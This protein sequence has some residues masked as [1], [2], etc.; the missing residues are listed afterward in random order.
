MRGLHTWTIA[1][2]HIISVPAELENSL[3]ARAAK[4]LRE[5]YP[6]GLY[7]EVNDMNGILKRQYQYYSTLLE[8][9][10]RPI[11]TREFLQMILHQYDQSC[12]LEWRRKAGTLTGHDDARWGNRPFF[13]R[14]LKY[15]AES[16]VAKPAKRNGEYSRRTLP[17]RV[18]TIVVAAEQLVA[19]ANTSTQ[20][21]ALLPEETSI[22]I[23]PDGDGQYLSV[24]SPRVELLGFAQRVDAVVRNISSVIPNSENLLHAVGMQ[25]PHVDK[26]FQNSLDVSYTELV[27]LACDIIE[28]IVPPANDFPIPV[29]SHAE[30]LRGLSERTHLRPS[31]IEL[32]IQG[33]S[34]CRGSLA[35][36]PREVFRP[37][38]E[39][40]LYRRGFCLL[41]DED[42]DWV[43]WSRELA[44]ESLVFLVEGAVFKQAPSEWQSPAI[45]SALATLSNVGGEWFEAIVLRGLT[46]NGVT[47]AGFKK[48]FRAENVSWQIPP[49]IG[50]IDCIFYCDVSKKLVVADSKLT[51]HSTEAA[52]FRNELQKYVWSESSYEKQISVK[53]EWVAQNI[54]RIRPALEAVGIL[55]KEERVEGV[56]AA[57]ITYSP[58]I[59]AY[60]TKDVVVIALC[61][62]L[63]N[64][65]KGRPLLSL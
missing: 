43:V 29:V 32:L 9:Q 55:G 26:A 19:F 10:L 39:H 42:G 51:R 21:Y 47:A 15:I 14:A 54:T 38:Q 17:R 18:T 53:A 58:S 49:Q 48:R 34:V 50:Q 64:R 25:A 45:E 46:S 13:R 31:Q 16:I 35:K 8:E 4:H 2:Q 62:V 52:L 57:I 27:G 20:T 63:N 22:V 1:D 3:I 5:V 37:N 28:R 36:V 44:K 24:T 56:A 59:A 60:F 65:C 6:A 30:L 61:E 23:R 7:T 40:R 12:E 33:F 41:E 11:A